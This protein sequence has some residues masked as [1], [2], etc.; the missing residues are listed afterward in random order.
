[1]ARNMLAL[2]LM[3][4]LLCVCWS[5][6]AELPKT[7]AEAKVELKRL[8]KIKDFS[9]GTMIPL[10]NCF[11]TNQQYL[12]NIYGD[13][14]DRGREKVAALDYCV[15]RYPD[16]L[17]EEP[18]LMEI[19]SQIIVLYRKTIATGNQVIAAFVAFNQM[20]AAGGESEPGYEDQ[21]KKIQAIKQELFQQSNE[22][23]ALQ[24]QYSVW[25]KAFLENYKKVAYISVNGK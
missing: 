24:K 25:Q 10:I 4:A 17:S 22:F 16:S 6:S 15:T 12:Q 13:Y 18:K 1:M 5:A 8:D 14:P 19:K 3:G 21:K 9:K 23:A 2:M 20:K 7:K 11:V